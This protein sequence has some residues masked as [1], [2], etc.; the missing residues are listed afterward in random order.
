L[1]RPKHGFNFPLAEWLA[2][3]D[4]YRRVSEALSPDAVAEAGLVEPRVVSRELARLR[5]SWLLDVPW[6]RA[7]RVWALYVLHEWHRNWRADRLASC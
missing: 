5:Q 2:Q 3:P 7:Q 4:C 6:L 1:H